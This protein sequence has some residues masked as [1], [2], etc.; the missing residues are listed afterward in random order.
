MAVAV[1]VT[2]LFVADPGVDAVAV[3]VSHE[4]ASAVT[5]FD[6]PVHGVLDGV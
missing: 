4:G 3:T 5:A 2:V 1:T 6:R